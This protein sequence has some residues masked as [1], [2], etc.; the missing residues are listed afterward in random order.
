MH[1]KHP[2]AET[3]TAIAV[4][5]HVAEIEMVLRHSRLKNNSPNRTTIIAGNLHADLQWICPSAAR[6]TLARIVDRISESSRPCDGRVDIFKAG[7]IWRPRSWRYLQLNDL[8]AR[9]VVV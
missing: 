6:E 3:K 4:R 9:D 8:T 5:I 7:A 2:R 1:A